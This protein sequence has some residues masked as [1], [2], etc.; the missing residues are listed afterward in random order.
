MR[1]LILDDDK[2]YGALLASAS[3][4][5]GHRG[6]V[7]A[8]VEAAISML[9]GSAD[10]G[11]DAVLI[12]LEMPTES[13]VS[14]ARRLGERGLQVPFAFFTGTCL[15][16]ALMQE[17]SSLGQVLPKVWTHADLRTVLGGLR[18]EATRLARA[19]EQEML[20]AEETN[21]DV[22]DDAELDPQ[23]ARGTG[24]QS[25]EA[26]VSAGRT[27]AHNLDPKARGAARRNTPRVRIACK[28]WDQV[29]R[30]CGD[31]ADGTSTITVRAQSLM[32]VGETVMIALGLPDEMIVSIGATILNRRAQAKN[33]KY[34]YQVD[35][36]GLGPEQIAYLLQCCEDN[37]PDMA[38]ETIKVKRPAVDASDTLR[39]IPTT[40]DSVDL[41][42]GAFD[43]EPKI[44]WD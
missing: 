15:D 1:I 12:D 10:P 16:E 29:R 32:E 26:L 5:I 4:K 18:E 28:S 22:P 43:G 2:S 25:Q 31:V 17:A 7:T 21:P 6:I 37:D 9:A 42:V 3:K 20:M 13:G 30:L 40:K 39:T 34:P 27:Q 38:T 24:A 8:D 33:G 36:V 44:S 19:R 14:F 41:E 35:L 23:F 11:F